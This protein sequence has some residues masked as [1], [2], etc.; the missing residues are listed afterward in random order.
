M[1]NKKRQRDPIPLRPWSR[2][3]PSASL[4]G[5]PNKNC[6]NS[7]GS[8]DQAPQM[9]NVQSQE[10]GHTLS[11][12][13]VSQQNE[14][15]SAH[16]MSQIPQASQ[17][18]NPQPPVISQN[19][20]PQYSQMQ[21]PLS[22]LAQPPCEPSSTMDPNYLSWDNPN[23]NGTPVA[24]SRT[25][26]GGPSQMQN[27]APQALSESQGRHHS[28]MQ[29]HSSPWTTMQPQPSATMDPNHENWSPVLVS[30]NQA[31][32][33]SQMQNPAPPP[34]P[35]PTLN[36]N[37][38]SWGKEN[39]NGVP[40]PTS[41]NQGGHLLQTAFSQ[42]P[43]HEYS[44]MQNQ[45]SPRAPLPSEPSAIMDENHCAWSNHN[46]TTG[47]G[48]QSQVG[49]PSQMQKPSTSGFSQSEAH[50]YSHVQ[51][52]L[53]PGNPPPPPEHSGLVNPNPQSWSNQDQNWQSVSRS[54]N[55][56]RNSYQLQNQRHPPSP[57]P[58]T[59]GWH[60]PSQSWEP[61]P[62][63]Q[64]RSLQPPVSPHNFSYDNLPP[65]APSRAMSSHMQSPNI[66]RDNIQSQ[67]LPNGYPYKDMSH[68]AQSGGF[69]NGHPS[70][71]SQHHTFQDLQSSNAMTSQGWNNPNMNPP[72]QDNS[73]RNSNT[74]PQLNSHQ[75]QF[76]R[77]DTIRATQNDNFQHKMG[78][79]NQQLDSYG[80]GTMPSYSNMRNLQTREYQERDLP[81]EEEYMYGPK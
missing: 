62:P 80:G 22:P 71:T 59:S 51:S 81:V 34:Q 64:S 36:S 41:H 24:G 3:P 43:A 58:C 6:M 75:F 27:P 48:S 38:Q 70:N 49:H 73:F 21:N 18:A 17:L 39:T 72:I 63:Y 10:P 78:Q 15:P 57:N 76:Q 2:P 16:P 12:P 52:H 50:Q 74:G 42:S 33:P 30:G 46:W 45:L 31:R 47:V 32:Y 25:A 29:M 19:Q 13:S 1:K 23:W 66:H 55:Q 60:S 4:S 9:S 7:V 20:A 69:H 28:P 68:V 56:T 40:Y 44:Q 54:E 77:A 61:A 5:S 65:P 35:L 37:Y 26:A 79:T 14:M 53:L 8:G 67:V 11:I